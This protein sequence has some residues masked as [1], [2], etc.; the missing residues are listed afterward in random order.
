MICLSLQLNSEIPPG[1]KYWCVR[2]CVL[3]L[4]I[5]GNGKAKFKFEPKGFKFEPKEFK[6]EHKEVDW[7]F[8]PKK[9]EPKF[10][11]KFPKYD[12]KQG[13]KLQGIF[14]VSGLP[15]TYCNSKQL[16]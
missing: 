7:K 11:L 16:W 15:C 13:R 8:V 4:L 12:A 14:Q 6:F 9:S 3:L 10:E 1:C 2:V 5:L